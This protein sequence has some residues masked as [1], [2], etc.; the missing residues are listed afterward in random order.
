MSN[1]VFLKPDEN[2]NWGKVGTDAAGSMSEQ[3]VF[4]S[5]ATAVSD[6]TVADVSGYTSLRVY[7]TIGSTSNTVTGQGS[8]DGVTYYTQVPITSSTSGISANGTYIYNVTGFKFFRLR[9]SAYVSGSVTVTGYASVGDYSSPVTTGSFGALDTNSQ[10]GV[11][12]GVGAYNLLFDGSAW[13]RQRSAWG[14]GDAHN[15]AGLGTTALMGFNGSTWDRVRTVGAG[16]GIGTGLL[17]QGGYV[18]DSTGLVWNRAR[19]ANGVGD[20]TT[21]TTMFAQSL[22]AFNG[23]S[24]DRVRSV[25]TG[26]LR[27]T[28][29]SSSGA[30]PN[31]G[32]TLASDNTTLANGLVSNAVQWAY[33]GA[34]FDKVRVGKVYK[35]IEFLNLANATATTVWTPASGKKF[36]LMGVSISVSGTNAAVHLRDGAGGTVFHTARASGTDTKDFYFGNGYL[37][38]A[39]N[40]VLEIYNLTG[41]TINVHVTAW[42][43]EE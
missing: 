33:N 39:A 40:N 10:N 22:M 12:L 32:N 37:S 13:A 2:G 17:A 29:Y 43:T 20:G 27:T 8:D 6:G 21:G 3:L 11:L 16:D 35:Y 1:S 7:V 41:S 31:I 23:T 24:W 30:E 34:A 38:T 42:G 4:Q 5:G 28:L 18:W 19:S 15:S 9:V 14:A 36:R 26:Q 25:N